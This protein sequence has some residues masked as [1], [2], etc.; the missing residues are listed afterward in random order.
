MQLFYN[1][2]LAHESF[3]PVDTIVKF[4]TSLNLNYKILEYIKTN[5]AM[6]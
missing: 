6:M 5:N 2:V 1:V 4:E 3:W